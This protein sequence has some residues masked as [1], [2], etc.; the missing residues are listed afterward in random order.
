MLYDNQRVTIIGL[1]REGTALAK[2]L[3]RHGARVTVTDIK[4]EEELRE[5]IDELADLPI[6]YLLDGHPQDALAA[7][8]IFVSPGVPLEIPL[9]EEARRRGISISS[10]TRLFFN[11]CP[12]PIIGIT[13]SSGKTTTCS[14]VGEI[15]QAAGHRTFVGGNIGF[16]LIGM[17]EEMEPEDKVVMEL[18]SF[19]LEVLDHSPHIAAVLNLSPNHLDRHPSMEHYV[20]AK[21]NIIRFQG[22]SDF[23]ILNADQRLTRD[24]ANDC[25]AQVLFFSRKQQMDEGAFITQ[26]E[27]TVRWNGRERKVCRVSDIQLLGLHNVENVL[28]AC[29][30]ATVGGAEVEAMTSAVTSFSGVPH[31]LEFVEEINGV[32]YYDDSIATS[33]DRAI[34][35]LS[36]FAQPVVLLAG[37][38]EK[39]L[40]LEGLAKLIVSKVKSLVLFGEAAPLLEQAV[41]DAHCEP[42]SREVPIY[43]SSNLPEAVRIAAQVSQPGDAVLLSPAC[44]SFDMYT[45]FAERGDHFK[46]LVREL[47]DSPEL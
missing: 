38:R 30:V 26:G 19:Q 24:L 9:L 32:R 28:A 35:A 17:V 34:A 18:S 44:T 43:R 5:R 6:S 39:H 1:G 15:M 7:D 11:L 12:A 36:S 29:A 22:T 47:R 42:T 21:A 41:N 33:P 2:F 14:L 37:G 16:P 31:R 3:V 13:G 10:E 20:A 40:P 46:S 8:V 4:G 27:I 25:R 23:V 45:D